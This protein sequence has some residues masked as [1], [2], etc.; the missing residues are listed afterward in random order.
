MDWPISILT[1]ILL[2]CIETS[3]QETCSW[4]DMEPH[5][6]DFG[7]AKLLDR[8]SSLASSTS[9]AATIGYIAPGNLSNLFR[10]SVSKFYFSRC[11][12]N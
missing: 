6:A 12:S 1:V 2:W 11:S 8:P 4:T 3:N 9:V 7:I 5:I 10:I